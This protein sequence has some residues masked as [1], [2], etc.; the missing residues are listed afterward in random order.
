MVVRSSA[1]VVGAVA[2][3]LLSVCSAAQTAHADTVTGLTSPASPSV[4]RGDAWIS[5]EAERL[6]GRALNVTCAVSRRDWEQAL[7]AVGL[8]GAEA[9]EYYGFSLIASGEMHL[10]PYVCAGL[11]LGLVPATRRSNELQAAWSA[12]VLVH[13]SVHMGR[14][15][16]DE[17]VAEAC[18]RAALPGELHRLFGVAYGSPE[19]GRLTA[20]AKLFRTT[21]GPAYQG[22][23]CPAPGV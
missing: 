1:R 11:R 2:A 3:L 22:G 21:M 9:D 8:P 7:R 4:I 15:T 12:D 20:A 10:S 23:S 13:E 6:S 16:A 19:L 5:A 14:F 17:A 18:A